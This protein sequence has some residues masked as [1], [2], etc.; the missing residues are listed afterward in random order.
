MLF[1]IYFF[2]FGGSLPHREPPSCKK[3]VG[4]EANT[5]MPTIAALLLTT[6]HS[7]SAVLSLSNEIKKESE[8]GIITTLK[9]Y[10]A[11]VMIPSSPKFY[12]NIRKELNLPKFDSRS[13]KIE[14]LRKSTQNIWTNVCASYIII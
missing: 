7:L 2:A 4:I 6:I 3:K 12:T 1:H 11:I 10:I 13:L 14:N 9:N 8:S 5:S